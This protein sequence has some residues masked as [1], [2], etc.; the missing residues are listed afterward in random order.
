MRFGRC[1]DARAA[2]SGASGTASP[3]SAL[4]P[5]REKLTEFPR[6]RTASWSAWNPIE[7]SASTKS[8]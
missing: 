3:R 8:A 2:S 6:I 7:F 5:S 1:A 4:W